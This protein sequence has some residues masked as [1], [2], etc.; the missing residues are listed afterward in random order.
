MNTSKTTKTDEPTNVEFM[1]TLM[2]LLP[3]AHWIKLS[4]LLETLCFIFKFKRD[5]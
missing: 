2:A 3:A 1:S 4:F 5:I